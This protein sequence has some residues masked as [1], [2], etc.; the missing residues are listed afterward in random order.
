MVRE[1]TN[2]PGQSTFPSRRHVTG[3]RAESSEIGKPMNGRRE[4]RRPILNASARRRIEEAY[5][6]HVRRLRE[7]L[8]KARRP[9]TP[10]PERVASEREAAEAEVVKMRE[11]P[12][13]PEPSASRPVQDGGIIQD[14]LATA[15]RRLAPNLGKALGGLASLGVFALAGFILAGVISSIKFADVRAA[16][17]ATSAEQVLGALVL[18]ALSYIALTGYDALALRQLGLRVR[19]RIAALAS[20]TSY[21]FSF[22]L[23][24]PVVTAAAVRYWIYSRVGVSAV[25][26]ANVTVIAGVT[27]WLGMASVVGVGLIE[28][29]GALAGI[30]KL[31]AFVNIALGLLICG[32]VGYYLVWVS[33]KP[34]RVRLRGH[35]FELPGLLPSAGQTVLGVIDL[36]CAAAALFWLLPPDMSLDFFTFASVYVFACL[37]GVVSHAPGGIGVFEATMLNALPGQSQESLLASLLLFRVLYYFLPFLFAL[38]LLGADEGSRRWTSLRETITRIMEAR[39]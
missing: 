14:F 15:R 38:A 9:E 39:E 6:A 19:Y 4:A 26:V 32:G 22:N 7:G 5:S 28:R 18:T 12:A 30:D 35:L 21:A 37:L 29:A 13:A 17:A 24:F 33:L 11:A 16:I 10:A 36:C 3:P 1:E 2:H 34:R 31:P 27:F 20:F 23:G 8:E 25:Q